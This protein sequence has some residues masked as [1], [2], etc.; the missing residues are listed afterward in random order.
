MSLFSITAYFS[1]HLMTSSLHKT[2]FQQQSLVHP[3]LFILRGTW[4]QHASWVTKKLTET[5][6]Q[7][8]KPFPEIDNYCSPLEK[9]YAAQLHLKSKK[10]FVFEGENNLLINNSARLLIS[11]TQDTQLFGDDLKEG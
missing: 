1:G 4:K 7:K 2:C 8:E 6:C 9:Q 5:I 11:E 10:T 3:P